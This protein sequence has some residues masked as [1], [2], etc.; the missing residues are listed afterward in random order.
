MIWKA[1]GWFVRRL[2]VERA[3][4]IVA[5]VGTV[6]GLICG[7]LFLWA[8]PQWIG[9]VGTIIIW[10]TTV[11]GILIAIVV[12]GWNLENLEKGVDAETLVG[13]A[14]ERAITAENCAVAH[15]VKEIAKVGDI[16]HIVATPS[17][18]WVIETKYKWVPKPFFNKVLKGIAANTHAVR[19]WLP[20]GTPVR[21]CLVLAFFVGQ[22]GKPEFAADGEKIY[23]YYDTKS[24]SKEMGKEGGKGPPLDPTIVKQIWEL[25]ET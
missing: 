15:S 3:M 13:R 4:W 18:V 20:K 9:P 24:L 25:S 16:D 23:A 6:A 12:V 11:V 10:G 8:L 14:I 2:L 1:P 22:P 5:G 21:G 7:P 17:A 19:E